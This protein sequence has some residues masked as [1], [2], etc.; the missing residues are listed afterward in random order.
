MLAKIDP[1][2]TTLLVCATILALAL[3]I[4]RIAFPSPKDTDYPYREEETEPSEI[5]SWHIGP[6]EK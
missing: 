1:V 3:I 2:I 5:K 6:E 4:T